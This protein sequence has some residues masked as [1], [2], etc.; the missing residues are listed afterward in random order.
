[1]QI[2]LTPTEHFI[3]LL[4]AGMYLHVDVGEISK[5]TVNRYAI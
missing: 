3:L 2:V 4:F 1:M 5:S